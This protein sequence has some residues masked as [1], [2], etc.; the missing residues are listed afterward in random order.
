MSALSWGLG[1]I[2]WLCLPVRKKLAV[3]NYH[4]CFPH[5]PMGELRRSVGNIIVQYLALLRGHRA[6]V[7]LPLDIQNGGV[8]LAGHGGAWD[9]A[10]ISVAE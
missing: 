7:H 4:R 1:W 8:C 6:E 10:L 2:W 9:M 3:R 5:R